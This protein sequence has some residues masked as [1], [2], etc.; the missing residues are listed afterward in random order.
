MR[1]IVP[2]LGR[3]GTAAS[4][5][6]L[7]ETGRSILFAVHADEAGAYEKAYPDCRVLILSETSRHHT[8]LIRKEIMEFHREPFFFVDDDI[9]ISLK[10]APSIRD[11]FD[12]LQ[13]H[14]EAGVAMAGLGAQLYSNFAME[15]T[16]LFNG[17]PWVERN[18]FVATV[19]GINPKDFDTCPLEALP[20]YEDVALVIHA[21][22]RAGGT[23]VTYQATQNNVSPKGGGCNSWRD[24]TVTIDCLNKLVELYPGICSVRAT[25]AMTHSQR[26]GIGLRVA[27]KDLKRIQ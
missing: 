26:L 8:G 18:K 7:R 24:S 2:S 25:E 4:M 21:V 13:R 11:V 16:V 3:A 15:K 10:A 9:R 19:Y 6:W 1:I 27:W 20:V 23:V 22:Q 12:T 5:K 17:D 14:M